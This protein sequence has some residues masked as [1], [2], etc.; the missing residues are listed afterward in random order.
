MLF[1][2]RDIIT[3]NTYIR[4]Y[5]IKHIFIKINIIITIFIAVFNFCIVKQCEIKCIKIKSY[6]NYNNTFILL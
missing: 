5:F 1:Y 4:V 2:T 6:N 3:K